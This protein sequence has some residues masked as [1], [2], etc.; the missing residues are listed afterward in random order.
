MVCK[1]AKRRATRKARM[2][3]R[4]RRIEHR[5]RDIEWTPQER[6]ML[7]ASGITYDVAGRM[8]GLSVGGI[9]LAHLLARR[10]GLV[11]A[12]D[13]S[14]HLLKVHLPYHESD[15]VLTVRRKRCIKRRMLS[16]AA[17]PVFRQQ[18]T[19]SSA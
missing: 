1:K 5:L 2:L 3:K 11:A 4:Q 7:R 8:H 13:R 19:K 18:M 9:G 12:I 15:H 16:M 17:C 6:P 14:L 10:S